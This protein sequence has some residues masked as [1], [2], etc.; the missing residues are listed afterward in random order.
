MEVLPLVNKQVTQAE[1]YLQAME[2]DA[3]VVYFLNLTFSF[4]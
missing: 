4:E 3:Y 2:V 1:H